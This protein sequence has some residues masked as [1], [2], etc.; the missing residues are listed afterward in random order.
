[1]EQ[2]YAEEGRVIEILPEES[3]V[4]GLNGSTSVSTGGASYAND[5]EDEEPT[6]E[7]LFS[8]VVQNDLD[9]DG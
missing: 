9:L 2:R 5:S 1:M 8:W 6:R 3:E 7:S 4:P